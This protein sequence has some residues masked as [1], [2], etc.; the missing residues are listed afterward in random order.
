MRGAVSSLP[1]TSS[2][3][4]GSINVEG[5]TP[6]PG[7]ELQ[8]DQ[9]GASPDYF[10]T[11]SIPLVKGRFFAGS[12]MPAT[13]EQVVLIDEK[14]AQRFWPAGDAVGRHV[15]FDPA[16]KLTIAGVVGTVKQY[17]L[18]VDGRM[19]VY[20]PS[21]W[22]GYQVA[23]TSSDPAAVARDMVRAIR[24]MDPTITVFDIQTM[25]DRMFASLAR[26]RF[27]TLMLGAFAAFALILAIVGVYGVMSHLVTQGAHDIGVR[28][29]LG[30]ERPRI[31]L[32][33]MRQGVELTVVGSV[34]G[35]I[36]AAALTR[37]MASLL[38][39]VSTTDLATFTAVPAILIATA[40]IASYLPA[41]RATR[42]DPVVALRDE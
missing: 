14:F 18:D 19:V 32:M 9:R 38:F 3:G 11:M 28:M 37:V 21:P 4:W 20:R 39:G 27:A 5:W 16:R 1:F 17:G 22:A 6:Q 10:R 31:L 40:M 12:D 15:W 8:V 7:Q 35:L 29:A 24:D 25:P 41:L 33:V 36:G 34:V 26:Q 2:V 42:V 30:A 13:A 23:R